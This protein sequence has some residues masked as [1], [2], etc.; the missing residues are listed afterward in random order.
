ML[1]RI[2][3]GSVAMTMFSLCALLCAAFSQ[4]NVNVRVRRLEDRFMIQD[5]MV[6]YATS[7]DR[8]DWRECCTHPPTRM[9]VLLS[10]SGCVC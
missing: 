5:L 7:V 2:R 1:G 8:M 4:P 6:R 3:V 10:C 9:R